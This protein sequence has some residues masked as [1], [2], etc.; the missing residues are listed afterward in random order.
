[1]NAAPPFSPATYGNRQMFPSPM[2]EPPT[3]ATVPNLLPND[4]LFA[5][6]NS[7]RFENN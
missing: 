1:M 4:P 5:M 7:C 6:P 2:T 3:A